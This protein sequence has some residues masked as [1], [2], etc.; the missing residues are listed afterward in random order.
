MVYLVMKKVANYAIRM[1]FQCDENW[2][3]MRPVGKSRYCESCS[4]YLLDFTE[5][6]DSEL[7]EYFKTYK[8]LCGKVNEVQ[9]N[10]ILDLPATHFV[11]AWK[12]WIMTF[13]LFGSLSAQSS[14][15]AAQIPLTV[16]VNIPEFL[17][18][19]S[20]PVLLGK[21]VDE[22]TGKPLSGVR[23]QLL[24]TDQE[25]VSNDSGRFEIICKKELPL[26][27]LNFSA[28]G[29]SV[30]EFQVK[31]KDLSDYITVSLDKVP[32]RINS[33]N[34]LDPKSINT[35]LPVNFCDFRVSV[36]ENAVPVSQ[37]VIQIIDGN[38]EIA[39]IA[40]DSDGRAVFQNL[41]PIDREYA[42]YAVK[43]GVRIDSVFRILSPGLNH[44]WAI[45]ITEVKKIE[46]HHYIGIMVMLPVESSG[47]LPRINLN[48]NE[49]VYKNTL[50]TPRN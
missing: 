23:V 32:E 4:R 17:N 35:E 28:S 39:R 13:G 1:D 50:K 36:T 15:G 2:D 27:K 10:R 18:D 14:L 29:Y 33:K 44:E 7:F 42:I 45:D 19:E 43:N 37:V 38:T 34:Y 40:T 20:Q 5:F 12:H 9:L 41:P 8:K 6:T 46:T 30:A 24:G 16:S 11:P 3:A 25:T 31:H 22:N 21:V 47:G 49:K 26:Y 48:S